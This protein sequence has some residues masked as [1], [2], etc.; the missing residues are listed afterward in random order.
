ML[1][2]GVDGAVVHEGTVISV[3]AASISLAGTLDAVV[4]PGTV[5]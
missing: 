4:Q 5:V 3:H 1:M 2:A